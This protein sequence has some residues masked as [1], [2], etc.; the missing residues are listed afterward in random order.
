MDKYAIHIL[1][2]ALLLHLVCY[3]SVVQCRTITDVD[4]EKVKLP[5]GFCGIEKWCTGACF[6]CFTTPYCYSSK[7]ECLQN[8][9][10]SR[11]SESILAAKKTTPLPDSSTA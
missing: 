4:N 9:K 11:P 5:Y 2:V 7:D 3:A 10:N 8:C 6:C 1:A